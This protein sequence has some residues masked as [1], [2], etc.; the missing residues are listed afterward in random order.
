[1]DKGGGAWGGKTLIHKKS[2][3]FNP[4]PKYYYLSYIFILTF[5]NALGQG[6][7]QQ[8]QQAADS[9]RRLRHDLHHVCGARLHNSKG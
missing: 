7:E 4:F 5:T 1:M 8:F 6:H 3:S 9:P 2:C